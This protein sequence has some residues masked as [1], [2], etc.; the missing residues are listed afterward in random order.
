M[1]PRNSRKRY[2]GSSGSSSL[3]DGVD[4]ESGLSTAVLLLM[5]IALL[6]VVTLVLGWFGD[7]TAVAL[8]VVCV[9][10][11]HFFCILLRGAIGN[12]T[13]Y[14]EYKWLYIYRFLCIPQVLLTMV[15]R[16]ITG[17]HS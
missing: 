8:V 5:V 10:V 15:P 9:G 4:L 3:G 17:G 14:C 16:N 12:R 1:V 6:V 11:S 13:K 2:R 7:T